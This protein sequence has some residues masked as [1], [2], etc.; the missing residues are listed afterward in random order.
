M[1][2]FLI[3]I[4]LLSSS[5]AFKL[6]TRSPGFPKLAYTKIHDISYKQP[7]VYRK[8][9]SIALK[10][11]K[12]ISQFYDTYLINQFNNTNIDK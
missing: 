2:L 9:K 5:K 7:L 1:N 12:D 4:L 10:I 3:L 8:K 11:I 6:T